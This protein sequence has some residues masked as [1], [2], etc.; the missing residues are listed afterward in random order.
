[1]TQMVSR[2]EQLC[3]ARIQYLRDCTIVNCHFVIYFSFITFLLPLAN[4]IAYDCV[5]QQYYFYFSF[6]YVLVFF[7]FLSFPIIA[8]F[9]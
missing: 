8:H 5:L 9:G 2:Y 3:M 4:I 6:C 1:M 7:I